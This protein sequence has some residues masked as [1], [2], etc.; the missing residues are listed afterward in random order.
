M[1]KEPIKIT[2]HYIGMSD[3]LLHHSLGVARKA[4]KIA[5]ERGRG[6]MFARKLWL[7]AWLHDIGYEFSERAEDHASVSACLVMNAVHGAFIEDFVFGGDYQAIRS[8][9]QAVRH[10]SEE[11]LIL[12]LADMTTDSTGKD[13]TFEER[14]EDIK[15]RHGE[16]SWQY[17]N[18]RKLQKQ[19]EQMQ[20]EE[21]AEL[22][23][24]CDA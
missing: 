16:D 17:L 18:F 9:G 5:L 1:E 15:E 7:L 19:I 20:K 12:N 21:A 10:P 22:T 6:E 2:P 11:W 4:Y 3:D 8:H 14:A 13:V 24:V 23:S